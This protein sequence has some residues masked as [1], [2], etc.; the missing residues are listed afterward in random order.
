MIKGMNN[1]RDSTVSIELSDYLCFSKIR[2]ITIA[3]LLMFQILGVSLAA[4]L[5]I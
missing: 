4:T 5:Y 1:P 2:W 3:F